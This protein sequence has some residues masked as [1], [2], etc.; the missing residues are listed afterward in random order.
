MADLTDTKTDAE[1]SNEKNR[2][3]IRTIVIVLLIAGAGYLVYRFFI[4]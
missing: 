4:K 1:I 2:K 3:L